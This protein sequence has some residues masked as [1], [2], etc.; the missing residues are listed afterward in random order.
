MTKPYR[1]LIIE[2]D[3]DDVELVLLGFSKHEEFFVDIATTGE[4]GLEKIPKT[5]YDLVSVDFALPGIS[6]LD[7]LEEIRKADQDVPVVMVTGRGTEE[8]QVVAFEKFATSYVIK[9]VD[10]LRSLPTIFEA[11]INEARFRFEERRM[12]KD[13]ERSE[14]VSRYILE[15]SPMG[16]YVL[17]NGCFKMV[18]SKF[19][20]IFGCE[21][22]DLIGEHFWSLADPES[23]EC[24]ESTGKDA[25]S[26][27]S[28]VKELRIVRK[29]GSKRWVEARI[30]PLDYQDERW[31]LGSLVDIT[32]RKEGEKDLLM[33]NIK[34][35]ILYSLALNAIDFRGREEDLMKEALSELMAGLKGFDVGGVFLLEEGRL[36]LQALEGPLEVLMGFVDQ[37]DPQG[38]LERG[39]T[40]ML[41]DVDRPLFW[42]STPFCNGEERRGL[43]VLGRE[44]E[45][46]PDFLEFMDDIAWHLG[47]MMEIFLLRR[48]HSEKV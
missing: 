37:V 17:Q 36:V 20:E 38:L 21:K 24:V 28:I 27:R 10:S 7:V 31:V 11:L 18:N 12:K 2:D 47:K 8:L 5:R 13:V 6:G 33:G 34:L 30:A 48:S 40:K 46:G 1:I 4:E 25:S 16:I 42:V 26:K 15:N 41:D 14:T 29:D 19:G 3:P 44:K 22:V 39:E 32:E 45:I 23:F 43:L 9:S 35:T